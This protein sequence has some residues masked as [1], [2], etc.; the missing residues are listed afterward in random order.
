MSGNAVGAIEEPSDP[1]KVAFEE[2]DGLLGYRVR[3]A[4]GAMHR[5]FMTAVAGLDLTQKQAAT[6][7]LINGNAGISQ[8]SVSTALGMDRAT[9]MTLI[10]RLEERGLLIRRRSDIDHRRQ[11][12]FATPAG[13]RM[14]HKVKM[15]IAGHEARF[16][17]LFTPHELAGLLAA[18]QRFQEMK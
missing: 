4:Q 5:H 7:W 12:L 15:R 10:E 8:M 6:L 14:L 9:T 3:R 17:S 2:L 11:E 13:Q 16:R 1:P 18:L